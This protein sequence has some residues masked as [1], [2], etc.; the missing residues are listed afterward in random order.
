V[1][2][3][4]FLGDLDTDWRQGELVCFFRAP[5]RIV[6]HVLRDLSISVSPAKTVSDIPTT[7]HDSVDLTAE[8]TAPR[9]FRS[10]ALIADAVRRLSLAA[11]DRVVKPL[12][13]R[14][15]QD[16]DH[17][18]RIMTNLL[19]FSHDTSQHHRDSESS[20]LRGEDTVPSNSFAYP[21][22]R[23]T[24]FI[25]NTTHISGGDRKV[26]IGYVFEG[27]TLAMVCQKNAEVARE[28][29]R[30]DHERIFKILQALFPSHCSAGVVLPGTNSLVV[31]MVTRM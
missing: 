31:K 18:L 4:T 7:G 29:G 30:Y 20:R 9:V 10:P 24:V 12:D 8:H 25:T 19:T 5:P 16:G 11:T 26:A 27:E 6:R 3:L 13:P 1:R 2:P 23:S 21:T 28:H 15:P 17:I 14:R 22:Q